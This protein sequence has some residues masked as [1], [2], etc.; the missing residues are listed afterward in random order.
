[1]DTTHLCPENSRITFSNKT[2]AGAGCTHRASRRQHRS[3]NPLANPPWAAHKTAREDGAPG[4]Q[5]MGLGM[6]PAPKE[7]RL[8]HRSWLWAV[9]GSREAAH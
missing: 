8:G 7:N 1:M 9:G 2:Q 3:N 4:K 5:L 6:L